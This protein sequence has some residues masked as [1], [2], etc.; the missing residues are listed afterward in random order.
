MP[1]IDVTLAEGR[2]PETVREFIT[3]VT[4][5]AERSLG[6]PRE[7]IRVIVRTVPLEHWANGGVTLKEKRSGVPAGT[8]TGGTPR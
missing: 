6:A 7:T 5:A 3:A 1:F 4:D 8:D 2:S